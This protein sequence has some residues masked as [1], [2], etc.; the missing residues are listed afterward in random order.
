MG[1][2]QHRQHHQHNGTMQLHV[3][4]HIH[5]HRYTIRDQVLDDGMVSEL[6]ISHTYRQDTGMYICHASNAF[7]QVS[8]S[9]FLFFFFFSIDF[10]V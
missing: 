4:I 5:T 9:C 1:N 6:G 7:G 8:G 2:Q 10:Y 3:H